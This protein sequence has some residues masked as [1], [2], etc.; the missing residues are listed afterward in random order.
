MNHNPFRPIANQQHSSEVPDHEGGQVEGVD[1]LIDYIQEGHPHGD[2][3]VAPGDTRSFDP[4]DLANR[5]QS[6]EE[7]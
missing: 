4:I 7:W 6:G 1:E 3:A 5:I 2:L